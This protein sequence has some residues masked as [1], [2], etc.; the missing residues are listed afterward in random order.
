MKNL[1]QYILESLNGNGWLAT[2]KTKE[3]PFVKAALESD[4]WEVKS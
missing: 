3:E 1:T 4:G 2:A